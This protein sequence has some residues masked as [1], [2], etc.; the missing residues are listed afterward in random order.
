VAV[1]HDLESV[2]AYFDE[3]LILNVRRIA[4]GPTAEVLTAANLTRA[5]GSEIDL[6]SRAAL[7]RS[8]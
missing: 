7:R 1:H 8:A 4:A 5:Y 2:A 6:G 3:L